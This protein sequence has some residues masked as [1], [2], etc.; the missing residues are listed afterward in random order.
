MSQPH[1]PPQQNPQQWPQQQWQQQWAPPPPVKKG[2]SPAVKVLIGFGA[3]LLVAAGVGIAIRL[4]HPEKQAA[5]LNVGDCVQLTGAG[6]DADAVKTGCD[7]S[8][9]MVSIAGVDKG[10]WNCSEGFY[11]VAIKSPRKNNVALCLALNG[12]VGDCFD[13]IDAKTPPK[14]VDC[15]KARVKV[16]K[17]L[18]KV[19]ATGQECGDAKQ[20]LSYFT[21]SDA[22]FKPPA[23][24]CFGDPS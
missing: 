13:D 5:Q 12:H 11:R 1:F 15:S 23:T 2:L 18:D 9:Y 8:P 22:R 4:P 3:L 17:L 16:T 19:S 7:T 6:D 21:G 14:L 10:E 20:H 24:I